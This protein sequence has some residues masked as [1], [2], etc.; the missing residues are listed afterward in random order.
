MLLVAEI[1]HAAGIVILSFLTSTFPDRQ[2]PI[3]SDR[4]SL[5]NCLIVRWA[6][7]ADIDE[8][9]VKS[10]SRILHMDD[11]RQ[12]LCIPDIFTPSGL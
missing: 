6:G 5:R 2:G 11:A 12:R 4:C 10:A 7:E 9:I 3:I 1:G 8:H